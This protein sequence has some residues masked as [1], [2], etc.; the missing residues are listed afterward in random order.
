MRNPEDTIASS[1]FAFPLAASLGVT[2]AAFD[3]AFRALFRA[4]YAE[5]F[6]LIDRGYGDQA[7]AADVAQETFV[8][9]YRRGAMPDDVRGWLGAVALNLARDERRRS[10]RRLRLL[11]ARGPE[12]TMAD[13][14]PGPDEELA[15]GERRSLVRRVL[16]RLTERDRSLLLLREEGYSY[17][18][19][20]IALALTESSIG[21][22]LARA[23]DAFR[24]AFDAMDGESAAGRDNAT[25]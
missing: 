4:R 22:M 24:S 2:T 10:S 13:A 7:L 9:L 18:E 1:A 17:R 21:T 11:S 16:D 20:A 8:R 5:L 23:R 6:R 3:A 19:I 12:V 15:A 25:T 14:T